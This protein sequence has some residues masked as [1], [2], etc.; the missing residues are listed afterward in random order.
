[1]SGTT[2]GTGISGASGAT[3]FGLPTGPQLGA[4]STGGEIDLDAMERASKRDAISKDMLSATT[5]SATGIE[6]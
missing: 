3:G 4:S 1:M 2:G 5:G 6:D